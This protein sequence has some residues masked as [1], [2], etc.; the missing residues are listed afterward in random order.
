MVSF[1]FLLMLEVLK[2][3]EMKYVEV[4]V[5]GMLCYEYVLEV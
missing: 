4:L 3:F 5:C 2:I 1:V